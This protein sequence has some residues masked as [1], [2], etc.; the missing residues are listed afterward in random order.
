MV[1]RIRPNLLNIRNQKKIGHTTNNTSPHEM[2][3]EANGK[4]E[5]LDKITENLR[6]FHNIKD[7]N[8]LSLYIEVF[9]ELKEFRKPD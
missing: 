2:F 7:D 9:T 1:V 6:K 3:V 5:A 8:N 4:S